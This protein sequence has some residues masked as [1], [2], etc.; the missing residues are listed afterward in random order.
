V[1]KIFDEKY[2]NPVRVISVGAPLIDVLGD[3]QNEKW[4]KY[5]IEFCG[6]TH[7]AKTGDIKNLVI[8]TE[9]SI[10]KGIRRIFAITGSDAQE[11]CRL[12]N[13]FDVKLRKVEN[14]H[15]SI[16]KLNFA[17]T[18]KTENERDLKGIIPAVRRSD[19]AVR[20]KAIEAEGVKMGKEKAKADEKKVIQTITDYFK[21]EG[22]KASGLVAVLPVTPDPKL[23][24]TSIATAL[25]KGKFQKSVYLFAADHS[26]LVHV[27]FVPQVLPRLDDINFAGGSFKTQS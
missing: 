23:L 20:I 18:L 11:A 19:F 10:A 3:L 25:K 21:G 6:G 13:E 7:V 15:F 2:P 16:E 26:K 8:L 12:A 14:L 22:G 17:A 4:E 27:C 24:T 1:R 5:S 9:E